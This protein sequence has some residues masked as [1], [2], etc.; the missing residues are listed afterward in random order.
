MRGLFF[1]I[2]GKTGENENREVEKREVKMAGLEEEKRSK[3]KRKR[4]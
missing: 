1:S 3:K 4:D 2:C